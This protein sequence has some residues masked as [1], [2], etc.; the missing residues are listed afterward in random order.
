L[1]HPKFTEIFI[2]KTSHYYYVFCISPDVPLLRL[3]K[4]D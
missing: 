1:H 3:R 2:I 4:S